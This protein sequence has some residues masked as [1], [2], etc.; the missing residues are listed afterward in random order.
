MLDCTREE[1]VRVLQPDAGALKVLDGSRKAIRLD[2][3]RRHHVAA[4]AEVG[5]RDE[6]AIELRLV[7]QTGARRV[8]PVVARDGD[9]VP[10]QLLDDASRICDPFPV[11]W[12]R[13]LCPT[14]RKHGDDQDRG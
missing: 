3:D 7:A 13:R 14:P 1:A 10:A 2:A 11:G 9:D 5:V 6:Q 4:A 12:R 8:D